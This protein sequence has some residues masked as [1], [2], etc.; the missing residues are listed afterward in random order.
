[1]KHPEPQTPS[2]SIL[3]WANGAVTSQSDVNEG[4]HSVLVATDDDQEHMFRVLCIQFRDNKP[5]L[6]RVFEE[7]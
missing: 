1:M 3:L 7:Y 5:A 6:F 4:A 2:I